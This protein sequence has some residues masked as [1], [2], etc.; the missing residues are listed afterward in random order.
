[1]TNGEITAIQ[2][3]HGES[4]GTPPEIDPSEYA[5]VSYFEN[6]FGEQSIFVHDEEHA[7]AVLYMGDAGWETPR[8]IPEREL[9]STAVENVPLLAGVILG[10]AE[11]RWIQACAK[12]VKYRL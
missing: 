10:A 5:F 1:M 6:R 2:N 12:A 7:E 8:R 11:E 4:C 9:E 3:R